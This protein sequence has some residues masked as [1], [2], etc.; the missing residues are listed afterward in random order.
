MCQLTEIIIYRK[1]QLSECLSVTMCTVVLRVSEGGCIPR[2][3]LP[4]YFFRH[5]C[6][7]M[8]CLATNGEKSDRKKQS[9]V[10]NSKQVR[11][12]WLMLTTAITDNGICSYAVRHTQY[13]RLSQRQQSFLSELWPVWFSF[14]KNDI[15]T[16]FGFLQ[17]PNTRARHLNLGKDAFLRH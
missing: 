4:I 6:S 7:G 10:R 12:C 13:D 3:A 8:Y 1:C 2:T 5:F 14:P 15:E 9:S 16:S 11:W 17:S